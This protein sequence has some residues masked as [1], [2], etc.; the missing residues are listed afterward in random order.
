MIRSLI[1]LA[2]L[3]C[4]AYAQISVPRPS[5]NAKVSQTIGVTEVS[6]LYSRPAVKGRE[7][8][9]KLVPFGQVWR[10]GANEN[11][12]ITFSDSVKIDGTKL[13]AGTY[14][15]QT[16]PG[17]DEWTIILS[18]D[19]K[20]W[21]AFNYK[22]END[23][24]RI[25]VKPQAAEFTERMRFSFEDVTEN[26]SLVVLQWEKLKVAFKV[27]V[28]T[29]TLTI[30]KARSVLSWRAS[31]TAAA[32]CAD[33]NVNIEDGLKW[34]NL[35]ISIEENYWNSAVKSRL[36]EKSGKTADAIK[37]MERAMELS[38]ALKDPPFNK[39][40]MEKLLADWKAA[41]KK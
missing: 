11:T 32:Y 35:S 16:I 27:E 8:W 17:A 40:D 18:K 29:S 38:K 41:K 12:A 34:S 37:T 28:E 31:N 26:S 22:P 20:E 3:T 2:L 30:A 19:A 14:G 10:T 23:V 24:L 21:G 1:T 9:N 4:T 6:M 33:A 25:K 5:P 15:L 36:L 7:I 13:L 39:A